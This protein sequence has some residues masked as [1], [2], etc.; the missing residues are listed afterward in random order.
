M[1]SAR[2]T[3][4]IDYAH[5]TRL[6]PTNF[7][8][9][10]RAR[11]WAWNQDV[12]SLEGVCMAA[13]AALL[14]G[15]ELVAD[16]PVRVLQSVRLADIVV[17]PDVVWMFVRPAGCT[18]PYPIALRTDTAIWLMHY[19]VKWVDAHGRSTSAHPFAAVTPETVTALAESS[20]VD[21]VGLTLADIVA[22]NRAYLATIYPA[23]TMW[24][25]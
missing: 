2:A 14:Y 10:V 18:A 7:G 8:W 13:A 1:N 11:Q 23:E 25:T 5:A 4:V 16:D 12:S 3:T 17:A 15:G 9:L 19:V 20:L 24:A 22:A 21:M 6:T